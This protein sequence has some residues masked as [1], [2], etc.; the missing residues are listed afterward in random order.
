MPP[1]SGTRNLGISVSLHAGFSEISKKFNHVG[2][3]RNILYL[4]QFYSDNLIGLRQCGTHAKMGSWRCVGFRT[5]S[6]AWTSVNM[7][8]NLCS[9]KQGSGNFLVR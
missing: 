7:G 8:M 2:G 9:V 1:R 4:T 6:S 5:R 3:R